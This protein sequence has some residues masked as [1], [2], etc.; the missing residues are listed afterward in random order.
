MVTIIKILILKRFRILNLER[1]NY[2]G[3]DICQDYKFV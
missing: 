3:G 1:E 2:F